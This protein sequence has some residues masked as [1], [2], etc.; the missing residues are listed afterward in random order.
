MLN[1]LQAEV[2]QGVASLVSYFDVS[3]MPYFFY[4]NSAASACLPRTGRKEFLLF[5]Q[6]D[7][8]GI[9]AKIGHYRCL[10]SPDREEGQAAIGGQP[11]VLIICWRCIDRFGGYDVLLL[12]G[13]NLPEGH[14]IQVIGRFQ[15]GRSQPRGGR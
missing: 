13:E 9:S 5:P 12:A 15:G 6:A 2:K 10:F 7:A 3:T 8:C 4:P 1:R 11:G 14:V